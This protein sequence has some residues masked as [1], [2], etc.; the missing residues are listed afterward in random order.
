[1]DVT[2][3]AQAYAAMAANLSEYAVQVTG[4]EPNTLTL[5]NNKLDVLISNQS[6]A[7][8]TSARLVQSGAG[9]TTTSA[10]LQ[11]LHP[12]RHGMHAQTGR[13]ITGTEHLQHSIADILMTRI[14]SRVMRRNYG[15]RLFEL[16]DKPLNPNTVLQWTTAIADALERW[17][18]RFK[19]QQVTPRLR[20]QA[21]AT[22]GKWWV[23]LAGDYHGSTVKLGVAL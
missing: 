5:I 2:A 10:A 23:E 17:E 20:S 9:S 13:L 15:S 14:G 3:M 12:P 8:T 7:K 4:G 19:L 16:L 6:T 21:E 18:P 1:M 11:T 22:Q